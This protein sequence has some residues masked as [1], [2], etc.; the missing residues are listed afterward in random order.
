[1]LKK[2]LTMPVLAPKSIAR[3]RDGFNFEIH[4]KVLSELSSSYVTDLTGKG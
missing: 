3:I 1:M 2:S 4:R